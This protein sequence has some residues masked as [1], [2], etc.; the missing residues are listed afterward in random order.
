MSWAEELAYLTLEYIGEIQCGFVACVDAELNTYG[1]MM[2]QKLKLAYYPVDEL[3][4]DLEAQSGLILAHDEKSVQKWWDGDDPSIVK[5]PVI[6]SII[7]LVGE[8]NSR[9][10]PKSS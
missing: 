4:V 7:L 5:N 8:E 6:S 10:Y 1:K 3:S 9:F 2:A